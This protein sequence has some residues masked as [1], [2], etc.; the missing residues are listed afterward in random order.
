MSQA[1]L[2]Q[3]VRKH[4]RVIKSCNNL[5]LKLWLR[6]LGESN[7]FHDALFDNNFE[8]FIAIDPRF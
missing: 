5:R 7:I 1:K 6:L 3:Y 2:I 8:E 4:L